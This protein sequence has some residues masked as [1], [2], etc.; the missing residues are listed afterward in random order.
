[1]RGYTGRR[2]RGWNWLKCEHPNAKVWK[3]D[4]SGASGGDFAGG[5]H[6]AAGLLGEQAGAGATRARDAGWGDC[7]RAAADYGGDGF[8]AGSVFQD[9]CGILAEPAEFL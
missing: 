4:G 7:A 6:E 2:F 5:F 1:M 3:I 8:A 9:E